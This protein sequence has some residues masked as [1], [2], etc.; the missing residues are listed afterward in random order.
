M[1]TI[2]QNVA[3]MKKTNQRNNIKNRTFGDYLLAVNLATGAL[4]QD[5]CDGSPF[6][7]KVDP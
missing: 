3:P 6:V 4:L 5:S 1:T 2:Q 7:N